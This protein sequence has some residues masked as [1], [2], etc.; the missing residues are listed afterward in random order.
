MGGEEEAAGRDKPYMIVTSA[1][2]LLH[3]RKRISLI[4][5]FIIN[6][7]VPVRLAIP[8]QTNRN[9]ADNPH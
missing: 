4:F 3:H 1:I 9:D 2:L 8:T 6:R 7:G 5:N